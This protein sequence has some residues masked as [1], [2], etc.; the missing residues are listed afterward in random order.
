M[1]AAVL[2][3]LVSIG[4]GHAQWKSDSDTVKLSRWEPHL[5][6]STGF[7]GTSYGDNRLYTSVAPSLTF[8]PSDRWAMNAGFRITT[9]MGLNPN[10]AY[11]SPERSLAP[12]KHRNGGTGLA[13]AH[14]VAQYQV[15]DRLWLAAAVY[16]LGGTY[17]PVY[18]FGNGEVFDVSATAV[19]AAASYR[20]NDD[21]FLHLSFTYVRDEQGTLPYLY[22][23]AWMHG[24]GW[25]MY[26]SPMGPYGMGIAHGHYFGG[27]WY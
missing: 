20:F 3:C 6:V 12:Y 18:G 2:V 4:T 16:H 8:R 26:A 14:V 1:V 9:D 23:D 13:A 21:S 10:Y 15:S 11:S 17:A 24:Y 19:S 7:M 22:H 5:Q 25:G 27:V